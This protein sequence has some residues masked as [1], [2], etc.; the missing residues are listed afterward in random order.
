MKHKNLTNDIFNI[1]EQDEKQNRTNTKYKEYSSTYKS[2]MKILED[3]I[4]VTESKIAEKKES[5]AKKKEFNKPAELIENA[6]KRL[7]SSQGREKRKNNL[8]LYNILNTKYRGC[9]VNVLVEGA[10]VTSGEVVLNFDRVLAL[11]NE[12]II[13]FINAEYILAFF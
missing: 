8:T 4:Q 6:H 13:V 2:E 5:S 1:I 11:K 3:N 10:G 9:H 12:N 7:Q